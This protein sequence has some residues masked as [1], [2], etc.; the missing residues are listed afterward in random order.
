MNKK[1]LIIL[2]I[3][4]SVF[5]YIANAQQTTNI[6]PNSILF[7][8]DNKNIYI[9]IKL[10]MKE[11]YINSEESL[12]LTP[13]IQSGTKKV[14]LPKVI[15]NGKSKN[16]SD[17]GSNKNEAEH[18]YMVQDI[19]N[20]ENIIYQTTVPYES[21]MNNAQLNLVKNLYEPNGTELYTHIDILKESPTLRSAS[22]QA[23]NEKTET[24][25]STSLVIK[26]NINNS[27]LM[28]DI[29]DLYFP[30]K[31]SY[32]ITDKSENIPL[33]EN[34][35]KAIEGILNNKNYTLVTIYIAAYTSPEGTYYDNEQLTKKQA[36]EFKTYLQNR[37]NYP[38]SYFRATWISED[39]AGLLQLVKQSN[40]KHKNSIIDII[41]NIGIFQ[42]REKKL[43]DLA[44]GNPYR[45]MHKQM[46]PQLRKIECKIIYKVNQ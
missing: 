44:G 2:L 8:Q 20:R 18:T 24:K 33:I 13:I 35:H 38:D 27:A 45:E 29:F 37:Y 34:I 46:F 22:Q 7:E 15:L 21:W 31:R 36:L 32:M 23:S 30:T 14:T 42:G 26:A 19:I 28:T 43:M 25:K 1:R 6:K 4:F 41:N 17:K 11:F 5:Q 16:N 10:P 3:L 39:W 40:I 9:N 12:S